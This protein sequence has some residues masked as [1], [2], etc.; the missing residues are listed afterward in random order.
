MIVLNTLNL[1]GLFILK[2][3]VVALL[4]VAMGF[5]IIFMCMLTSLTKAL[6]AIDAN[7]S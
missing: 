2:C 5:S 6:N 3:I 7:N 1:I 4:I